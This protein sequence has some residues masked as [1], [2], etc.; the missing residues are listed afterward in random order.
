MNVFIFLLKQQCEFLTL[1]VLPALCCPVPGPE[2]V[3]MAPCELPG[4]DVAGAAQCSRAAVSGS[5][6]CLLPD[7]CLHQPSSFHH[8]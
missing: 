6:R 7:D 2:D 3:S 5:L 4:A 8:L 1:P